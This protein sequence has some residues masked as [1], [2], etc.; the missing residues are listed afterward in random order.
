MKSLGSSSMPAG[1]R[2]VSCSVREQTGLRGRQSLSI[3]E[4]RS[5]WSIQAI[6]RNTIRCTDSADQ[7]DAKT[8]SGNRVENREQ[9]ETT[10]LMSL[11]E[12]M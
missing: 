10:L 7:I 12:S 11:L 8:G 4:S 3:S 1:G 6:M 2:A 5:Q 9:V